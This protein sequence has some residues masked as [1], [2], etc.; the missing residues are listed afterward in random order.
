MDRPGLLYALPFLQFAAGRLVADIMKMASASGA[1][2]YLVTGAAGVRGKD[3][4][5]LLAEVGPFCSGVAST[6]LFGRD[7]ETMESAEDEVA[8]LC[9]D[10]Q[11][12]GVH[13]FTAVAA[14]S[15]VAHS[16]TVATIV[17]WSPAKTQWQRAMDAE[18]LRR[19]DIVTTLSDAVTDQLW[20]G[21]L[22]R[23]DVKLIRTGVQVPTFTRQRRTDAPMS[24][25]GVMAHLTERKGVDVLLRALALLPQSPFIRLI[26]AGTGDAEASLR[27]L[28]GSLPLA[29]TVTWAGDMPVHEF[30]DVI[31][32]AVV[33]SRSDA[34]PMVLLQAM[35]EGVPV[36]GTQVGAIRDAVRDG[37]DGLLVPPDDVVSLSLAIWSAAESPE[38]AR[39][40][41]ESA[42][43]RV[44]QEF[45]LDGMLAKYV[46]CYDEIG[47]RL[48]VS[49]D[50]G[51]SH[52][53]GL[54]NAAF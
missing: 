44:A 21:G 24:T 33:P 23:P 38:L 17:G 45:T 54:R 40:R 27:D 3:D 31:D 1:R 20:Q 5:A 9:V 49:K 42:R 26:V 36:V 19:C 2:V 53:L 8:R 28:A 10:W 29:C 47:V 43:R 46:A 39:S 48:R 15:A 35:A 52:G 16:R 22:E 50:A 41:A 34:L 12:D 25:V 32:L 51:R 14:A 6:D 7:A 11:I 4:P 30:L 18:I 37:I 13:A